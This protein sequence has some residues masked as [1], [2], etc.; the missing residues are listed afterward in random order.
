[1]AWLG[2]HRAFAVEEFI[3]N[4]GSQIMTRRAFRSQETKFAVLVSQ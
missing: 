2:Q 1:M 4:G 3:Q